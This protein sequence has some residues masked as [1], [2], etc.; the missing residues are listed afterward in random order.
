M[1]ALPMDHP[2]ARPD[3]KTHRRT[4]LRRP[5]P[6]G[7]RLRSER[8]QF[9][10]NASSERSCKVSSP[11]AETSRGARRFPSITPG[12]RRGRKALWEGMGKCRRESET[13]VHHPAAARGAH[14]SLML[15]A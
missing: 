6:A 8:V 7:R 13:R 5:S 1:P 15:W 9:R 12:G 2:A 11:C 3:T 10:P 14:S 4:Q